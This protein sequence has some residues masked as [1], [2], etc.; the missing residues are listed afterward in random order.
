[1]LLTANKAINLAEASVDGHIKLLMRPL[2]NRGSGLILGTI[3][4][5][6][7]DWQWRS[8]RKKTNCSHMKRSSIVMEGGTLPMIGGGG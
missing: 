5:F 1:M 6:D 3:T 7:F 4:L 8:F 2:A